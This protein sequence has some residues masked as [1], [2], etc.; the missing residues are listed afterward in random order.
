[1][2]RLYTPFSVIMKRVILISA[3]LSLLTFLGGC[4]SKSLYKDVRHL[5]EESRHT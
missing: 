5:G 1:M 3:I 2:G 4:T